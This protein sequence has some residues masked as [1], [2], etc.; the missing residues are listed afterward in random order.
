MTDT[1]VL[2]FKPAAPQAAARRIFGAVM[3]GGGLLLGGILLLAG[4]LFLP[5]ILEGAK[6][7]PAA[8]WGLVVPG[9]GL[10][11]VIVFAGVGGL[12]IFAG[13]GREV[14]LTAGAMTLKRRRATTTLAL[15]DI[16]SI[17]AVFVRD[18]PRVG[19][20]AAV[21]RAVSGGT[22]ELGIPQGAYLA[23]F[24]ARPILVALLPRLPA[25]AD[26]DARIRHY[27]ATGQARV[28]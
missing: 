13:A 14:R 8:L 9:A 3:A 27:A 28:W 15:A 18:S 5:A 19:H 10:L 17:G 25:A 23:M 22:I 11:F 20:W 6:T 12:L 21:I 2:V 7:N 24:D 1:T 4:V 16:A 26:V